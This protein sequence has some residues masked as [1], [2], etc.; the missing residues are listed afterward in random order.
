MFAQL[1]HLLLPLRLLLLLLLLKAMISAS[2][3]A[4]LTNARRIGRRRRLAAGAR[5]LMLAALWRLRDER[6]KLC[7]R[8]ADRAHRR[9]A[10]HKVANRRKSRCLFAATENGLILRR[11]ARLV[12]E[13]HRLGR[14]RGGSNAIRVV[15]QRRRR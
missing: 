2:R 10:H 12:P 1:L 4:Q 11:L 7:W 14:R 13:R 8:L 15:Q 9:P 3:S 6:C 5:S